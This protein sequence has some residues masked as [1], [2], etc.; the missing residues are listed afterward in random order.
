MTLKKAWPTTREAV[1]FTRRRHSFNL[2]RG[3]HGVRG[4][5]GVGRTPPRDG[6]VL[7]GA[8]PLTCG[9]SRSG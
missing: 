4:A 8:G 1:S 2:P 7:R 5:G 6:E 3:T 9:H